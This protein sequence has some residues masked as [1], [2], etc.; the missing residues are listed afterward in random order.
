MFAAPDRRRRLVQLIQSRRTPVA[1]VPWP[2]SQRALA[3]IGQII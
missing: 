1:W 3:V 2:D